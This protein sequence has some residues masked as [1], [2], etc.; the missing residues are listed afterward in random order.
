[1][2]DWATDVIDRIGLLGVA[3][4]V[5]LESVFPPIPSE[6]VLLLSGFNVDTGRFG[7][8]AAV[9]AATVGSVAGAWLLYLLGAWI[10]D[11]R[12]ERLCAGVGR[13]LGLH[14][15]DID[16]G[17]RWFERHGAGIVFFGRLIPVVRSVVSIPAGAERMAPLQFTLLTAAGSLLW[18]TIWI[19]AGQQLGQQ[20]QRAEQWG[21]VIEKV[22]LGLALVAGVVLVVRARRRRARL[23]AL[24]TCTADDDPTVGPG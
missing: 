1:V 7:L 17:F 21:S 2:I 4:L 11:D 9:L 10:D 3:F 14:R 20:W 13:Y 8:V 12:L 16:T 24:A 6:L 5:A 23:D 19:T 22:V 18:N 15:D